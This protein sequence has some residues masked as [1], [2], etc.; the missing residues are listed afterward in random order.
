[1]LKIFYFVPKIIYDILLFLIEYTKVSIL[2]Y[3]IKLFVFTQLVLYR[4]DNSII[5][6][7]F[8]RNKYRR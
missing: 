2:Y 3:L 4:I 5:L 6:F 1:M 7:C 8:T